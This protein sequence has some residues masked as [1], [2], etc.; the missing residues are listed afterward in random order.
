MFYL[1]F[2][3][4]WLEGNLFHS[5]IGQHF[6]QQKKKEISPESQSRG[7]KF[8]NRDL[9]TEIPMT[10]DVT[11][12]VDD[13]FYGEADTKKRHKEIKI[14]EVAEQLIY[15]GNIA[16]EK[17]D[18]FTGVEKFREGIEKYKQLND[19]ERVLE[20]LRIVSQKCISNEHLI[21][22]G[23]FTDELYK[24]AKKQNNRFYLGIVYYTQGYLLLKKG[25]NDVLEEGLNKIQDAAVNFEKEGDFAGAGMCFNKIGSIYHTRLNKLENACLFYRAAI[26]NFNNSIIKMHRLRTDFWNKQELLIQKVVELRDIVEEMLPNLENNKLK[27]KITDDLK[28]LSYNF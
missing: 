16:F 28:N 20:L 21:F 26:E 9:L 4:L 1:G 8:S 7:N 13:I 2:P 12:G 24:L 6:V 14:K 11:F 23:E 15:E 19:I 3:A 5:P 27:K 17:R 18:S 22:A 25:D 10:E